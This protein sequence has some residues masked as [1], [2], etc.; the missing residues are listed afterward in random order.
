VSGVRLEDL[1]I[2]SRLEVRI[3]SRW[4][5]AE[6]V[7]VR[8]ATDGAGTLFESDPYRVLTCETRTSDGGRG[9][10]VVLSAVRPLPVRLVEVGLFMGEVE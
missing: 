5:V 1:C 7:D 8:E 10:P 6:V 2:G 3:G 9:G 4:I